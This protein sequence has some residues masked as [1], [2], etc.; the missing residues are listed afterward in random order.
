M[1]ER[2]EMPGRHPRTYGEEMSAR[3]GGGEEERNLDEPENLVARSTDDVSALSLK[4]FQYLY[5][6]GHG[7]EGEISAHI[8]RQSEM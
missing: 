6:W 3:A 7:Q 5:F 8:G 2:K 4:P 1:R